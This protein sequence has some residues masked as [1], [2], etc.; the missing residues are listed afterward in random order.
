MAPRKR[1]S[2]RKGARRRTARRAYAP[3]KRTTRR[4]G[5]VS[6][7]TRNKIIQGA[8]IVGAIGYFAALRLQKTYTDQ[9]IADG[10]SKIPKYLAE[11]YGPA[12]VVAAAGYLIG[13]R[14]KG[15]AQVGTQA[16]AYV[17]AAALAV[18]NLKTEGQ[19]GFGSEGVGALF[20]R[21]RTQA[22]GR[23][24]Q[25][26]SGMYAV[27]AQGRPSSALRRNTGPAQRIVVNA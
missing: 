18:Q 23:L 6:K 19:L 24:M 11:G 10:E 2:T 13:M 9:I 21:P 16:G 5:G 27:G 4:K 20:S 25:R 15:A 12:V 26:T 22:A 17:A 7:G 8:A 1:R 3:K 14:Q